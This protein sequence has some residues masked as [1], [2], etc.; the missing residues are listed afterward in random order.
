MPRIR[1]KTSNRQNTRDRAKITKKVAESRKKTKRDSK[2]DTTWK[3][4]KKADPGIP[5]SFFLKDKVLA[6]QAAEKRRDEEA[7][8][9]RREAAKGK[10]PAT[11][12]EDDA[13]G[14]SS[15]PKSAVLSGVSSSAPAASA[16]SDADSEP[17][18]V[19][20]LVDT[21]LATLQDVL[22]RADV[23]MQVVD[24]RDILGGR[25][26]YVE[27][28]V[29]EAGGNF[30]LLVN[31]IDLVP[32]ESLQAWL[33]HLPA[34]TYL[35]ESV[36]P[37]AGPS[38][39]PSTTVLGKNELTAAL[40]SWSAQKSSSSND[41]LVIA[42]MGLPSVGK[43]SV[44]NSL[45]PS[46]R[47][48]VAGSTPTMAN[49]K[50]P[51]PTTKV[52]V[53]VRVDLGD[54]V[55]RVIDTPGWEHAED[56][57]EDNDDE[58]DQEDEEEGL[59]EEKLAKWDALEARVA[60]DMLRRNLGRV[61]RVKDVLPLA[62]YIISRSNSQ[63]L[64]LCYNI[65]YFAEGD[66][67]AFLTGLARANGRVRKHGD[68]D[69]EA[70]ARIVVRDWA[71]NTFP[72]Y[73]T[74]PK[75]GGSMET[76]GEARPDLSAVLEGMKG[77]KEMKAKGKGLVRFRSGEV[78][79]REVILD[80]DY[81]AMAGPSDEDDEEEDEDDEDGFPAGELGEEE[82]E[83]EDEDDEEVEIEGEELD[84][85][86]GPE[87]SSGSS[88]ADDDEDD[89]DEDEEDEEELPEPSSRKN[90]RKAPDSPVAPV[91][92]RK[93]VSFGAKAQFQV[94]GKTNGKSPSKAHERAAKGA[95]DVKGILKRSADVLVPKAD[96][97][98]KV[99]KGVSKGKTSNGSGKSAA[100]AAA[101]VTAQTKKGKATKDKP[102]ATGDGDAYDF[103]R[104]F[105]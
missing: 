1:K 66:N 103:S 47:L 13:P 21:A 27:G 61:D 17:S 12:E 92:K 20:D 105:A 82:D 73:C 49:A 81:T 59:S 97:K 85:E 98:A 45:L 65:P 44:L 5:N 57:D 6:Q 14:I 37:T 84:L 11:E 104:H 41:E 33:P 52:P 62:N 78:D 75:A 83:D 93:R 39:S 4:K 3:S 101:V 53:E 42:L 46:P 30:A 70:A 71:H 15:L 43:T 58:E 102:V 35:I 63:D 36:V 67:D 96:K 74:P 94:P 25:S 2:R 55:V 87:P 76:D 54:V 56:D 91:S 69:L 68:P 99:V 10:Q 64:M 86:S 79:S 26:G 51:E 38:S 77:K 16:R 90:K 24:A 48:G 95:S 60:G 72:Y 80:D 31:K 88:I 29:K 23:V 28:L 40:K 89:E 8:I 7:K 18:E 19:P 32:R 34:Q 22:D 9:A 100:P 50:H